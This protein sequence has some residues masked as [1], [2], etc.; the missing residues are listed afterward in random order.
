MQKLRVTRISYS[1]ESP[2]ESLIWFHHLITKVIIEEL[3]LDPLQAGKFIMS[4]HQFLKLI[5]NME[6]EEKN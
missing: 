3:H 2:K 4:S 1:N 6:D 5:E